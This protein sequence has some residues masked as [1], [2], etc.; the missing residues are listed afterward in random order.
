MRIKEE[1]RIVGVDCPTCVYNIRRS[2][3][4]R[5]ADVELEID[6]TRVMPM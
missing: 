2:I 6:V 4:R 1:I 3:E 5:N